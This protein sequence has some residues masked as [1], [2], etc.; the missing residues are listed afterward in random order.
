MP[1][2]GC[3][4]EFHSTACHF[5]ENKKKR[6]LI[7]IRLAGAAVTAES[8]ADR[9]E[10]F[11]SLS[12]QT[13]ACN[14]ILACTRKSTFLFYFFALPLTI[15]LSLPHTHTQFKYLLPTLL[16]I[17]IGVLKEIRSYRLYT[18]ILLYRYC[19]HAQVVTSYANNVPMQ[20]YIQKYNIIIFHR[21]RRK[22][23]RSSKRFSE[24]VLLYR[25]WMVFT[26]HLAH[27]NIK[28][29]NMYII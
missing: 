11:K 13:D 20:C 18:I 16:N 21:S 15:S 22:L 28:Y 26:T 14:M 10:S 24:C 8:S 17:H 25:R 23:R 7:L 4:V 2:R 3:L 9:V 5:S 6:F 12:R 27:S 19:T 29:N 1:D